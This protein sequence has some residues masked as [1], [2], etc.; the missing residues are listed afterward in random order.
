MQIMRQ[1]AAH[2]MAMEGTVKHALDNIKL[3]ICLTLSVALASYLC[4]FF[5]VWFA[6]RSRARQR[7]AMLRWRAD[8]GSRDRLV[9]VCD[10]IPLVGASFW[11]NSAV[12]SVR[13]RAAANQETQS[14]PP[15]STA[16]QASE[17]CGQ[18]VL[19]QRPVEAT[20]RRRSTLS[21]TDIRISTTAP[22]S[23]SLMWHQPLR[24]TR[25]Y[26]EWRLALLVGRWHVRPA[27]P[28]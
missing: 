25:G 8:C 13:R 26:R 19:P 12:R 4:V 20:R 27:R 11:S 23:P 28:R 21:D 9:G 17:L 22:R 24:R 3:R 7:S 18:Q 16:I 5:V 15:E 1:E 2:T 6:A 10:R 14:R